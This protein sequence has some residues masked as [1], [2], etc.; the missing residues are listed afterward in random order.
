MSHEYKKGDWVVFEYG[1]FRELV[2]LNSC[3]FGMALGSVMIEYNGR[4]GKHK[5]KPDNV[6]AVFSNEQK[7]EAIACHKGTK[8]QY[9]R[10][11]EELK[12]IQDTAKSIRKEMLA[13]LS[14][15]SPTHSLKEG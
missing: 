14:K 11:C 2:G 15:A 4:H 7:D 12:S 6:F 9:D 3:L 13:A 10:C 5:C 8:L 1:I